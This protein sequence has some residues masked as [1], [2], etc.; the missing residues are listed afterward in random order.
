MELC[1]CYTTYMLFVGR[2]HSQ[3][4]PC[5]VDSAIIIIIAVKYS[6]R[7]S[8]NCNWQEPMDGSRRPQTQLLGGENREWCFWVY[9]F[10]I[11]LCGRCCW[12]CVRLMVLWRH[13]H[14]LCFRFRVVSVWVQFLAKRY[15]DMFD[16]YEWG[17]TL[18]FISICDVGHCLCIYFGLF[19]MII[20]VC[21]IKTNI[22]HTF[23]QLLIY[24]RNC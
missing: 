17:H 22:R 13:W 8:T 7:Y 2:R 4:Q 14:G 16:V 12:G 3:S 24:L 19:L 6:P 23:I 21:G 11:A 9:I 1:V 18:W 20:S 5:F 15:M 10:R